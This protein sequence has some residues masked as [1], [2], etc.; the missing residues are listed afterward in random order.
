MY[1][2]INGLCAG[3]CGAGG[4]MGTPGV[5]LEPLKGFRCPVG[6]PSRSCRVN[7]IVSKMKPL[8]KV[9]ERKENKVIEGR[10]ASHA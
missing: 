3:G 5:W 8:V 9:R 10:E 4:V 6:Q 2:V 1:V 7:N